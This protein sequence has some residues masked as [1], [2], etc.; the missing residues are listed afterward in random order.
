[1]SWGIYVHVPWCTRSC[2]YCAFFHEPARDVPWDRYVDAVL[3]EHAG[4]RPLFP[5]EPTTLYLG[6]G[7]PSLLPLEPL[8]RLI[9]G[10]APDGV[11]ELTLEV[12]PEDANPAWLAGVR[13]LGVHRLSL[14]VQS[15]RGAA[16][17]LGRARSS[18]AAPAVIAHIRELGFPSWSADLIFAVPGQTLEEL[19]L[20]LDAYLAL[21]PPHLSLYGLTLEPGTAFGRR[22]EA[23]RLRPLPPALWREM[24]DLLVSTLQEAGLRRYEVSN[25]ARDGHRSRHNRLYW[26]DRPYMGLGPGAHGY[27]PDGRRWSNAHDIEG[28]LRAPLTSASWERPSPGEAAIDYLLSATRGSD[29]VDLERL[30][31]RTGHRLN[32]QATARLVAG[33]LLEAQAGVLTLTGEGYPLCDAVISHLVDALVAPAAG[34]ADRTSPAGPPAPQDEIG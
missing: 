11:E 17:T 28:Y 16:K 5:G 13:A 31:R 4:L 33:G 20:D 6:G 23:G 15:L 18:R 9:A 30:A 21:E 3:A 19:R 24:Y 12:N 8:A 2:P 27:A 26:R 32:P 7:S 22:A 1:M 34:A 10:L 14:G 29:G 25:F